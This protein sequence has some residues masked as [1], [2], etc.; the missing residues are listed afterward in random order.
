MCGYYFGNYEEIYGGGSK[1]MIIMDIKA[2]NLYAFKNFHINMSYPKKIVDSSIPS[3]FL[4]ERPNFR[5]KKINII[6]GGNASGKTSLG[7]L[8]MNFTNYFKDGYYNRF[9]NVIDNKNK[10]SKLIVDFITDTEELYRFSLFIS[11]TS[12]DDDTKDDVKVSI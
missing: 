3:E 1:I 9:I 12:S 5:Y 7:K 6:M 2:D 4:E 10:P 11:P 8:I